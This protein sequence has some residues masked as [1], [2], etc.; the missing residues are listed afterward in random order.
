MSLGQGV[1][2]RAALVTP[3]SGPLGGYGQAGA[4][5][6]SLWAGWRGHKF[7]AGGK[8]FSREPTPP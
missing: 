7:P 2:L 1:M 8:C 5:A 6:L 3:L 4:A